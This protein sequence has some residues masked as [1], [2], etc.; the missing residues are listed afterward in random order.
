M[1]K[2]RR[3]GRFNIS[4]L[5]YLHQNYQTLSVEQ[6][7]KKINR[8]PVSI[9]KWI[10]GNIGLNRE[11]KTEIQGSNELKQRTYYKE[12]QKQFTSDELDLF[13]FHFKKMWVQFKDDVF[14]TEEMQ[15]IDVIKYEI[16]MNRILRSQQDAKDQ[17]DT[18]QREIALEK[19]LEKAHQ[20][21]DF[22][23]N[24][25]RQI[26]S[27]R[28]AQ[29]M[30]GR[31]FKDYQ[32]RKAQLVKELKGTREQRV[33]SIEDAK[34]NFGT[35][36]KRLIIDPAFRHA[37]GVEMET[38]RIAAENEWKRLSKAMTYRDG[39]VDRPLLNSETVMLEE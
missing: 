28:S 34:S 39:V 30:I 2:K 5:N 38:M 19:N 6:M 20:D 29:E 27:I 22:I 14:H 33:K 23:L 3:M 18:M 12:L 26:A 36:A 16:L 9:H 32:T 15:I 17:I 7:A 37:V 8:D 10:E 25:E 21:R 31:D 4:E 24:L 35:L 11:Q 13:E 1:A